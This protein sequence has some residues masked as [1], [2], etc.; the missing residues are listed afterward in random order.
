[1]GTNKPSEV[2]TIWVGS[3]NMGSAPPPADLT[4]WMP[5][6]RADVYVVSVLGADYSVEGGKAAGESSTEDHFFACVACH[7]GDSSVRTAQ[8]SLLAIRIVVMVRKCHY[9]QI[10]QPRT[11]KEATGIGGIYG[12]K[13]ATAV[14]MFFNDTSLCFIGC[15]LAAREE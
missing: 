5:R 12:N 8:G 11:A 3:W 1:D 6:D 7:M 15:H 14:S 13:G 2:I 4:P 10:T 9:Y